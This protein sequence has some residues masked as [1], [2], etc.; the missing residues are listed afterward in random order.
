MYGVVFR[1]GIIV[2]SSPLVRTPDNIALKQPLVAGKA[3]VQPALQLRTRFSTQE[4]YYSDDS[5]ASLGLDELTYSWGKG[6]I[7]IIILL[8]ND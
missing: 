5:R 7:Y 6:M 1:D 8:N 4:Y 3:S 2:K